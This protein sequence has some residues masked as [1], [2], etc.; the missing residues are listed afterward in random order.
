MIDVKMLN[1]NEIAGLEDKNKGN[2]ILFAR[3]DKIIV[4]TLTKKEGD[5]AIEKISDCI[6]DLQLCRLDV[7]PDLARKLEDF[8]K[9]ANELRAKKILIFG[10][11]NSNGMR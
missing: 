9:V 3:G 1:L 11:P 2:V 6:D 5:E 7:R 8:R 4:Q 10:L